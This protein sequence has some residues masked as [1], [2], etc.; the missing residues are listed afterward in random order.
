MR[1]NYIYIHFCRRKRKGKTDK[2]KDALII[3]YMPVWRRSL[4]EKKP[5]KN[6]K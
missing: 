4:E 5:I 6:I 1:K 3:V 2:H